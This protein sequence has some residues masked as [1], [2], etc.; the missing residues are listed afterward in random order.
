MGAMKAYLGDK[1]LK[2]TSTVEEKTRKLIENELEK[3]EVS[4]AAPELAFR[5]DAIQQV[6]LTGKTLAEQFPPLNLNS[7]ILHEEVNKL[8]GTNWVDRKNVLDK[9]ISEIQKAQ[10][11]LAHE[12]L[13]DIIEV[14]NRL[15]QNEK[16]KSVKKQSILAIQ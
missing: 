9:I 16:N 12:G 15:L 13:R 14:V 1:M 6:G 10:F 11:H 4:N 5:P 2:L 3:V 8:S 7:V